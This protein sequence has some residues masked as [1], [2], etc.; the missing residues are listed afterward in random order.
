MFMYHNYSSGVVGKGGEMYD[1]LAHEKEWSEKL[2]RDI[3]A[4]FLTEREIT[5]ILDN[6]DIWMDGD[7]VIKRLKKKVKKLKSNKKENSDE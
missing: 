6:K 5:S 1:R 3:Y 7:E 4:D 2:M